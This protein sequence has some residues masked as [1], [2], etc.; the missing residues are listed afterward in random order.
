LKED[1]PA[2]YRNLISSH[3]S[4][5]P[6]NDLFVF[7]PAAAAWTDLTD[8]VQ[9]PLPSPRQYFGF[10]AAF[11]KLFSFGGADNVGVFRFIEPCCV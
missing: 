8:A 7:D 6:V 5:G 4:A 1:K 10:T 11:G 2:A 3:R 9:G